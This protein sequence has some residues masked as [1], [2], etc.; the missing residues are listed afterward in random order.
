MHIK[1]AAYQVLRE[2]DCRMNEL[3]SFCRRTYANDYH[4][5]ERQRRTF[6][7]ESRDDVWR[8]DGDGAADT[9]LLLTD[10]LRR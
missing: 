5:Y 1:R 8:I 9:G 10:V 3:E 4:E 2:Q 6:M 7:Q